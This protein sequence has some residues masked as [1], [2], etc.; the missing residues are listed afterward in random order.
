[1]TAVPVEDFPV[2]KYDLYQIH[3]MGAVL[4]WMKKERHNIAY[5]E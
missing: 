3:C 4:G 2:G 1:M 5:L